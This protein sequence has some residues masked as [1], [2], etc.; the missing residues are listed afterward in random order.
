MAARLKFWHDV[1]VIE[2]AQA[3]LDGGRFSALFAAALAA[4][5]ILAV[6]AGAGMKGVDGKVLDQDIPTIL[7][8]AVEAVFFVW[9]AWRFHA[10]KGSFA[11]PVA[12]A[13]FGFEAMFK[14]ISGQGNFGY[15]LMWVAVLVGLLNGTRGAWAVRKSGVPA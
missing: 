14:I 4:L 11:G 6:L 12:C 10:G 9:C 7:G 8:I 13:L 1:T 3:A 2:G 5:G 15:A